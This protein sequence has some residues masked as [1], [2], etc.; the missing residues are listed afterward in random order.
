MQPMNLW[1]S[2]LGGEENDRNGQIIIV[3]EYMG[4]QFFRL[5]RI[6]NALKKG[7]L[8]VGGPKGSDGSSIQDKGKHIKA[9]EHPGYK[10]SKV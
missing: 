1:S 5:G 9:P 7:T 10:R 6:E 4:G 8:H 2:S 3:W